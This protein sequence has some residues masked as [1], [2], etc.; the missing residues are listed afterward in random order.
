M[1]LAGKGAGK[2]D[3]ISMQESEGLRTENDL[4]KQR[5]QSPDPAQLLNV[6]R[7]TEPKI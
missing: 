5:S 1:G 7:P 3:T 2:V 6:L 4:L